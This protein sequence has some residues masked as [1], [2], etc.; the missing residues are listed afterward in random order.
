MQRM[1]T[2]ADRAST[3]KDS[4]IKTY[5]LRLGL[6]QTEAGRRAGKNQDWW[7]RVERGARKRVTLA[8]LKAAAKALGISPRTLARHAIDTAEG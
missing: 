5:R 2:V 1:I 6:T 7:S 4:I 8:D 3:P